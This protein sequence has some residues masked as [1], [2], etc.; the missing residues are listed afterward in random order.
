MSL[1]KALTPS[2]AL[3]FDSCSHAG[4]RAS[5][6]TP[7]LAAIS[8]LTPPHAHVRRRKPEVAAPKVRH[9]AL[10][11]EHGPVRRGE[12]YLHACHVVPREL[13]AA[14]LEDALDGALREQRR[15]DSVD[16]TVAHEGLHGLVDGAFA[17][18]AAQRH[19]VKQVLRPPLVHRVRME[20]LR[21]HAIV[22][23]P[24]HVGAQAAPIALHVPAAPHEQKLPAVGQVLE[25]RLPPGRQVGAPGHEVL[26]KDEARAHVVIAAL[27][28]SLP[29]ADVDGDLAG[30]QR[31]ERVF[32]EQ[33]ALCCREIVQGRR[34]VEGRHELQVL[35]AQLPSLLH[36]ALHAGRH[37]NHVG[38]GEWER[39]PEGAH[40][41]KQVVW[42][43]GHLGRPHTRR[44]C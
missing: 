41:L 18:G 33:S 28:H 34:L 12:G 4:V 43:L 35:Q 39:F 30:G 3:S 40:V 37:D 29:M 9:P 11:H 23:D 19:A 13:R 31:T 32:A 15:A 42:K 27:L 10:G 26:L 44:N 16:L 22:R 7:R 6:R 38:S 1:K 8:I 14:L 21:G 24:V 36:H 5:A 25:A 20:A 2:P 17:Q